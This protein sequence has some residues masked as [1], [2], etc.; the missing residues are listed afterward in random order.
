MYSDITHKVNFGIVLLR[1][2]N[3]LHLSV[4]PPVK[5][6]PNSF[7]CLTTALG[8]QKGS[9]RQYVPPAIS[10]ER[11]KA[12]NYQKNNVLSL[13]LQSNPANTDSQTYKLTVPFFRLGTPEE[14][15]IV[16]HRLLKIMTSQNITTSLGQ[17]AMSRQILDRD[18]LACFNAK[19]TE[20]GNETVTNHNVSQ[21]CHRTCLSST[22]STIPTPVHVP[23]PTQTGIY[24]YERV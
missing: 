21:C 9:Q 12:R 10:L 20:L 8:L 18:T 19:A 13:K 4:S 1:Q 24:D 16:K 11:P 23:L 22:C 14:W 5:Q 17:Y 15:L 7:S 3:I 2:T 6:M